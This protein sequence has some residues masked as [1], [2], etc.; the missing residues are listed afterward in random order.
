MKKNKL[1]ISIFVP[2]GN[3]AESLKRVLNSLVNQTYKNF[4]VIIVDYK[5][6]DNTFAVIKRFRKR[7]KIKLIKQ[8]Q[9]GLSLAANM[10]LRKSEGDIFIRTDDDVEMTP[11]WLEAIN[12]TFISDNKIGGVTGP[13]IVPKKFISNRD[14]FVFN[15]KFKQGFFWHLIGRFYF[16]F[17]MDGQPY[18]VSHWFDSG[19]FSIGTNFTASLKEPSQETNN[20][21]ACN[22][23][24]RADLLRKI[25]GFDQV[26][27]GVGEYHE[28]DAAYKIKELGYRLIFNPK[29]ALFHCPSQDGFFNDRP[30]SY[31]RMCNFLSF[32][33]KHI[34]LD[35]PRKFFKLSGYILFQDCYYIYQGIILHQYK[36]F[37]AL[38]ASVMGFY[39]YYK[40]RKDEKKRIK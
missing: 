29:A 25:G 7:L 23:A 28:P 8:R 33:L 11:G 13:T 21:E 22:F 14:V 40:K 30:A 9:K 35:S 1:Y 27:S 26:Y 36:Q 5:S 12:G 38:P 31:P 20:L 39:Y 24:V 32:Y 18:K 16:N 6:K 2:T 4:E 10:A 17:L 19:A 15:I 3:R 34:K 37:G